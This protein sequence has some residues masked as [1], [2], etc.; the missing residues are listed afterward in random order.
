MKAQNV[1]PYRW[2]VLFTTIP[3]IIATEMMWLT[4]SPISS[5]AEKFYGVSSLAVTMLA[6]SYM[7]MFI[8]FCIPAAYV[9]DRFGFR[10]SLWIGALLTG[11]FGLTRGLLAD[12]FTAVIVSQFLI[13]AG[14]PFLLNITTKVAANW[15]PFD[16]RATAAGLL[17]MAQYLGFA[18]P[19]VL[20][21]M[22]SEQYGL[23]GTLKVFSVV[24][25]IACALALIFS[26]ERPAVAPPGPAAE[27]EDFS[28][29]TL[30]E[31]FRNRAYI[32]AM[33]VAFI[34]MG[35]FNTLLTLIESILMPRGITSAQAGI[36]GAAFVLAGVVG[37]IIL[38][39]I[40]D[41]AGKRIPFLITAIVL[42]VPLYLGLTLLQGFVLLTV[43]AAVAGFAIMGV[44]PILFQ[45]GSEVAYPIQEGTSLGM[46]LLMGQISGVLFVFLFELAGGAFG[47][48]T[49]PMLGVVILTALEIPLVAKMKE[50]ALIKK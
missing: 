7:L 13:A 22:L 26:R 15:F 38:P 11:I 12:S 25:V 30:K 50:S 33:L 5:I 24:G 49:V 47:G 31:L 44:A 23:P 43:T 45:H 40:S 35:I 18:L 37:A 6:T 46:I 9:I 2:V 39:I 42:L 32:I 17:T 28:L 1:S 16:E 10:A 4:F 36:I 3:A 41:K 27:K 29:S 21:P 34:S 20:S 19:M 8:V 14:Q 48:I